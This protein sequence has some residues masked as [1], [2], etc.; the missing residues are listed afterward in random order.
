MNIWEAEIGPDARREERGVPRGHVNDEQRRRWPDIGF[1][2][3]GWAILGYA[4]AEFF[5]RSFQLRREEFSFGSLQNRLSQMFI[6]FLSKPL[7][8][9]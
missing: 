8:K 9:K 3:R 1:P 6:L 4:I 2:R 7:K 5:L